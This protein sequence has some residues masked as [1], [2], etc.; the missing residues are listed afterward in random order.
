MENIEIKASKASMEISDRLR[1][2]WQSYQYHEVASKIFT[3]KFLLTNEKHSLKIPADTTWERI[4]L[5]NYGIGKQIDDLFYQI[6]NENKADLHIL[7]T[8]PLA[9]TGDHI[10]YHCLMII[11]NYSLTLNEFQD[12]K[13]TGLYFKS[14]MESFFLK[15]KYQSVITPQGLN[16]LMV[17]ILKPTNGE[18]YDGAAGIASSLI[19]AN[20]FGNHIFMYGQE[21][22][23]SSVAIAYMNAIVNGIDLSR[24]IIAKGDTLFSPAFTNNGSD[25]KKFDYIVMNP[26]FGLKINNLEYMDYDP[27]GRFSGRMGKTSKIH[28][29]LAFLQH[30]V[31]SL[32]EHGKATLVIPAGVLTRSSYAEKAFREYI[33]NAD[34][35]ETVVLLPNKIL[36]ATAVQTILLVLNKN[37]LAVRKQKVLFINAEDQYTST[38]RS[39]NFLEQ[40]HIE[41]IVSRYELFTEDTE[42]A[43]IADFQEIRQNDY[44]LNPNQY[45]TS[46]TVES[47]FGNVVFN[48][49]LYD[50][51]VENKRALKEI[52]QLSR[53]VNL[54]PKSKVT[55]GKTGYKIIQ[56]KDVENSTINL[57]HIQEIPV[58]NAERYMVQSG[59]IIIASRGTAFKVA[60]VPE[61][62]ESLVLSNMFIRIRIMNQSYIPE[63][64]KAFLESPVGI[65]LIEGMQKGGTVKALTTSD[66]EDIEFPDIAIKEQQEIVE[67]VKDAEQ[68][69]YQLLQQA[70]EILKQGKVNAYT[71]MGIGNVIEGLD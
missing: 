50:S 68:K 49:A 59:D 8:F 24:F 14:L 13:L 67:T 19:E 6:A 48:K 23:D 40:K 2:E 57:D 16:Q 46:H 22:M 53:G 65:A 26:P 51:K 69:Y 29:D 9:Q 30:A 41:A 43:K 44:N 37:K 45:F 21:I 55:E 60:I 64:I 3:A 32:N 18:V 38:G 56:L 17:K 7:N 31:A 47:E 54:P 62:D 52:A 39:Q 34:I 70:Q 36:P 35:I 42:D 25:L 10:L 5:S 20:K 15:D 58:Q 61:L 12:F 11:D 63:Y 27:Y 66:I 33:V 28:G 1:G 4:S 71:K